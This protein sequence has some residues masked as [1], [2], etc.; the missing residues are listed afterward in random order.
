MA[1]VN[2][3]AATSADAGTIVHLVRQLAI[4]EKERIEQ[5]KLTEADVIRDG[6]G[7][8]PRFEVIIA[9]LDGT[10]VGF[11]LFFYN[12]STWEGRSGLYLEDLFVEESARGHGLGLALMRELARIALVRGRARIDL[13]VL[14]WNP[15]REF[16]QRLGF[17]SLEQ[18]LVYRLTEPAMSELTATAEMNTQ[19]PPNHS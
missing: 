18:W 9:E 1:S 16:Y 15:T 6:F 8:H 3:R 19:T 5:V 2:I 17:Q 14:D 4:Y 11:A 13:S 10:P 7:E 12:Y